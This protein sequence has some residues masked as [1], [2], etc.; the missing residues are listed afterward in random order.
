MRLSFGL[1]YGSIGF[2]IEGALG[3]RSAAMF[4]KAF[5]FKEMRSFSKDTMG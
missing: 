5:N 1:S 2:E 4:S 3:Y